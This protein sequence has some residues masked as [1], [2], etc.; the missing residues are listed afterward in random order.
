MAEEATSP[1]PAQAPPDAGKIVDTPASTPAAP[2][3]AGDPPSGETPKSLVT[4]GALADGKTEETEKPKEEP[5]KEAD[6]VPEKYELKLPEN[7]LLKAQALEDI[8]ATAKEHKLTQKQAEALVQREDK[9]LHAY[10]QAQLDDLKVKSQVWIQDVKAD[11]ELGG[12]AFVKNAELASRVV[13]RFGTESFQKMI[14]DSGA[15]NHPELV[16]IFARI[17]KAMSEDQL[18]IPGSQSGRG[19]RSM[20]DIFYGE[21]SKK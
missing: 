2:K 20:E 8:A 3:P 10:H 18:V 5:P 12:E 15:G 21:Q 4:D 1:E 14:S 11:K 19:P 7:S 13:K 9:A 16:R 6:T 17:G